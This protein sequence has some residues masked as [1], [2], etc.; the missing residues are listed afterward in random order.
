MM[1]HDEMLTELRRRAMAAVVA[2]RVA[3]DAA[4]ELFEMAQQCRDSGM[5]WR[6]AAE[7]VSEATGRTITAVAVCS[8]CGEMAHDDKK[9]DEWAE[10][11]ECAD[12]S[13]N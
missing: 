2:A 3:Q 12:P 7:V 11:H 9:F 4:E 10:E 6:E 13:L 8:H 1:T 5:D